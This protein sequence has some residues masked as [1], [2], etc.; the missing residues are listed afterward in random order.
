MK[1]ENPELCGAA[2]GHAANKSVLEPVANAQ[3]LACRL[4][5]LTQR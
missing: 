2:W 5:A 1:V 4:G 3:V